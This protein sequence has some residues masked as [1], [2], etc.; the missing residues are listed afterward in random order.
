MFV[1]RQLDRVG[2]RLLSIVE[3]VDV[4]EK[5]NQ[6]EEVEREVG[7]GAT[8]RQAE[9]QPPNQTPESRQPDLIP[10]TY[11]GKVGESWNIEQT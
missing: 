9:R 1:D 6:V 4:A 2:Y 8:R 5:R 10:G 7:P 3:E 11:V